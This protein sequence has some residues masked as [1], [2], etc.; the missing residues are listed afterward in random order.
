LT[1]ELLPQE[2]RA[3]Y[4]ALK[5]KFDELKKALPPQYPFLQ[6]AAEFEPYDLQLNIRGSPAVPVGAVG[7]KDIGVP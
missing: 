2:R 5:A 7:R 4:D 1:P 6:G 3:E